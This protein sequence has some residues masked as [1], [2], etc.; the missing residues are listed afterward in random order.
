MTSTY[1]VIVTKQVKKSGSS[2]ALNL[3]K[4]LRA[5]GYQEGDLITV[6]LCKKGTV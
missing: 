2:L 1:K 3:T 6:E 4:E 5:L